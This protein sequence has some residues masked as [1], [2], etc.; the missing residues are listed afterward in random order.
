[1][2]T[3]QCA[4]TLDADLLGTTAYAHRAD[5]LDGLGMSVRLFQTNDVQYI[6]KT[7]VINF[8]KTNVLTYPSV[9]AILLF[10][11]ACGTAD[12]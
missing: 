9:L 8:I 6:C 5:H 7:C 3:G 2:T 10:Q 1:M 12:I 11:E 4:A